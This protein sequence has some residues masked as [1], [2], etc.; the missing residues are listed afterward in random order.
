MSMEKTAG[1]FKQVLLIDDNA[2]QLQVREAILR[3]EGFQVSIAT[4][5]ES[6]MATLWVLRERIGVVVTDHLMP[7]CSGSEL[8]RQIRDHSQWLPVIVLSGLA[9]AELEYQGLNV[10]FR[11]KPLPPP[12]LIELV[13]SSLDEAA[14]RQGA[15]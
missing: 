4:T 1:Y 6:A 9:E 2:L 11:T 15:A 13:R 12:E 8:V 10:A 7:D 3:N 5:A 14:K